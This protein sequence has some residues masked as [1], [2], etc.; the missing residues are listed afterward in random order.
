MCITLIVVMVSQVYACVLTH[1]IVH[2]KVCAVFV[3]QLY[4]SKAEERER[5]KKGRKEEESKKERRQKERKKGRKE[6]N[7][8]PRRGES[9]L[10]SAL[11]M[12]AVFLIPAP[13]WGLGF[14]L[15]ACCFYAQLFSP[16]G[17]HLSYTKGKET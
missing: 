3:Y 16:E 13:I 10:L 2:I 8:C 1:Q 17:K 7:S 11:M 6:E 4:F 9:F 12:S 15:F 14:R 5:E